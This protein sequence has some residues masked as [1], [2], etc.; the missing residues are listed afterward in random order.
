MIEAENLYRGAVCLDTS[1]AQFI[2][3]SVIKYWQQPVSAQTTQSGE[4]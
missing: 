2:A 1:P 4:F 3:D